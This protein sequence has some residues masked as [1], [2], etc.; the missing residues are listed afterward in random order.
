MNAYDEYQRLIDNIFGKGVVSVCDN[1]GIKVNNV[2]GTWSCSDDFQ[3][4][5][6]NFYDR[7]SRLKN[8]FKNKENIQ[9]IHNLAASIG[10]NKNWEGAY[11]ELVAYDLLSTEYNTEFKL[12]VTRKASFA[13]AEKLG[14]KNINYDIYMRDYGVYM[15]VKAFTDPISDILNNSVIEN[16]LQQD[17]FKSMRLS[18]LPEHPLDESEIIY[19]SNVKALRVELIEHLHDMIAN[20][21]KHYSYSSQIV[22]TLKLNI[23]KGKGI[24]SCLSEY[25]PYRHAE[26]IKDFIIRRYCNKFPNRAPFY[27]VFV[28]FPWYNRV[29][30]DT[31]EYNKILYRSIARRTFIQYEKNKVRTSAINTNIKDKSLARNIA[32]KLTGIIFI[33]DNS[34]N[35][36]GYNVYVYTNPNAINKRRTLNLYLEALWRKASKH[37]YDDF[38]N[39]NY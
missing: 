19:T 25:S 22:K 2:I 14:M 6:G 4:F 32:R 11:A 39:D 7:L 26:A 29:A 20:G 16:V 30:T 34:I 28:N 17:D 23:L 15:D 36:T 8:I 3:V 21:K 13:I 35:G 9:T 12:D 38:I 5:K 31:F 37:D 1:G 33:D 10:D 27:L 24:N 18:I